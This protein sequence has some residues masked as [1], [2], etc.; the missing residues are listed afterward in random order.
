M[1]RIISSRAFDRTRKKTK[2]M[3]SVISTSAWRAQL[4]ESVH[5]RRTDVQRLTCQLTAAVLGAVSELGARIGACS[6]SLSLSD[7]VGE[8]P[9]QPC[10]ALWKSC[11]R[12]KAAKRSRITEPARQNFWFCDRGCVQL[13]L[14]SH[15][16]GSLYRDEVAMLILF[17]SMLVIKSMVYNIVKMF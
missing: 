13:M 8:H 2:R 1:P 6:L 15:Q 17:A 3:R 4:D 5:V 12:E 16:I 10:D 14:L 9:L 7:T 11:P